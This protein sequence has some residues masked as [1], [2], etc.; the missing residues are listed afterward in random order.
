MFY[1]LVVHCIPD[2]A[3][4]PL[5][6]FDYV[7]FRAG[8]SLLTAF[9][10]GILFGPMTVRKLKNAIAPARLE[11]LIKEE[12]IDHK[13]DKTPSMGGILVVA[14]IIISIL[15]WGNLTN[16]LLLLFVCTLAAFSAIGFFDDYIKVV[17]HNRDG[18]PARLK[19]LLQVFVSIT[20]LTIYSHL[21]PDTYHNFCDL[22]VP[23]FKNPVWTMPY[24]FALLFSVIVLVGASNA[25]NL[26]DG[27]DGLAVGCTIWCM[28]AYGIF[29][30]VS[31]NYVF[32]SHLNLHFIS[33]G[34]EIVVFSAAI[35]GACVGF[36]W[37]NCHPAAMFMGDTGSLALGG[38]IG[39]ISVLVNQ[40]FLLI[41]I[42]GV[43]LME[44]LSVM[45]QVASFRL[46]GKRIFR[47]T[48]IHHHFE[49]GGWGETQIVT[50]FWI[51]AGLFALIGLAT[52][53]LR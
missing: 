20:A 11:G 43:F 28:I 44:I 52:L 45:M 50:R 5:R 9:L 42:G 49:L 17:K 36:L 34:G 27:K 13:K 37:Y 25:V 48:P 53:K 24:W 1:F 29:A 14:S 21:S 8:A 30:Y 7:T 41:I 18:I 2:Y 16:A 46:T 12:V 26:T 38:I 35:I 33:Q 4:T 23:F 15:L 47:C 51:L 3:Q 39:F 6:L 40:E 10:I 19:F 32:A 22:Y 31:S